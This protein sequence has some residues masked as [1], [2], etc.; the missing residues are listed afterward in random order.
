MKMLLKNQIINAIKNK[1]IDGLLIKLKKTQKSYLLGL[2]MILLLPSLMEGK[3]T[4]YEPL[5]MF[6][7]MFILL[8]VYAIGF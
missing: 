8:I 2:F 6:I 5:S 1:T 7:F 4:Y 3:L